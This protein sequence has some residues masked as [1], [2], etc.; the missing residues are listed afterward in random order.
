MARSEI[1]GNDEGGNLKGITED[2][3]AFAPILRRDRYETADRGLR[4]AVDRLSDEDVG[5]M[6]ESKA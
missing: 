6:Y 5:E 4:V 1:R 2:G 3:A